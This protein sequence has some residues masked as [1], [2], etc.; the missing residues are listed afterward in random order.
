MPSPPE[1]LCRSISAWLSSIPPPPYADDK[2]IKTSPHIASSAEPCPK[3]PRLSISQSDD[4][5]DATFWPLKLFPSPPATTI[6]PMNPIPQSLR[7]K[8]GRDECDDDEDNENNSAN[9]ILPT[10][11]LD[12]ST[13]RAERAVHVQLPAPVPLHLLQNT[14]VASTTH[15]PSV[16]SQAASVTSRT[17]SPTKQMRFASLD[18]TG[19]LIKSFSTDGNTMPPSLAEVHLHLTDIQEKLQSYRIRPFSFFDPNTDPAS[20]RWQFPSVAF[21]R[22]IMSRA[23]QCAVA[24]ELESSWNQDVHR[25]LLDY[26]FRPEGRPCSLDFRYCNAASIIPRFRPKTVPSKMVDYC[27]H[28]VPT[29]EEQAQINQLCMSRPAASINHTDWG[30]LSGDPIALSV[31]TKR[32]GE[33]LE[34]ALSQIGTWHACQWRSLL[35]EKQYPPSGIEFLP[36]LIAQGHTWYFVATTRQNSGQAWL[37]TKMEVGTTETLIGTYQ[38]LVALQYLKCWI[39]DAYWPAF[40]EYML[41]LP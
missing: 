21:V 17:S 7:Q 20:H 27:V 14:S 6:S 12:E 18:V 9:A 5:V 16:S 33:G 38:I 19:Y 40:R 11:S 34:Q 41:A 24:R 15:T 32:D 8:R 3:K 39:E 2:D 37:Y 23:I 28:V 25:P 22:K 31:E 10:S 29:A 1:A 30:N 4:E 36:A 35:H 13:P 26:V